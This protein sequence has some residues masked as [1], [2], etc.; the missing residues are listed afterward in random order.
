MTL[1]L[2]RFTRAIR[3]ARCFFRVASVEAARALGFARF[4]RLFYSQ[5]VFRLASNGAVP[6]LRLVRFTWV[7][8]IAKRDCRTRL[9]V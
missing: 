1:G 3:I 8:R 5:K 4:A 9:F 7:I 6:A 2:V